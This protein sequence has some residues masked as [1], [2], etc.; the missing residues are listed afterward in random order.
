MSQNRKIEFSVHENIFLQML[1]EVFDITSR[2]KD[3]DNSN[4]L[5]EVFYTKLAETNRKVW[6]SAL[7]IKN[8]KLRLIRKKS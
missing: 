8:V 6:Y 2:Y 5:I 7:Q 3:I 1:F 4:K